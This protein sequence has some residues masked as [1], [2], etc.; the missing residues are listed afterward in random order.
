[1]GKVTDTF[2]SVL[3]LPNRSVAKVSRNHGEHSLQN[4]YQIRRERVD[5]RRRAET[6]TRNGFEENLPRRAEEEISTRDQRLGDAQAP[7]FF[8]VR[9]VKPGFILMNLF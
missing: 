4:A 2:F 7:G 9:E 8:E 1:L 6:T 3:L 5:F